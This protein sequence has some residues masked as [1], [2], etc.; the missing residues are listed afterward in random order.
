[1]TRA[2]T[3]PRQARPPATPA[4]A[5][6]APATPH[7]PAGHPD[8]ARRPHGG[9]SPRQQPRPSSPGPHLPAPP[10]L[11]HQLPAPRS[12]HARASTRPGRHQQPG[13]PGRDGG[14]RA[15]TV[16]ARSW[17]PAD[18]DQPAAGDPAGGL[19]IEHHQ[20]GTLVHGTQKN[21]HQ[22]RRVLHNHG[23][24]W[25]GNLNAW[26]LPRPWTFSTRNRRVSSLT[27]DL[28]QAH[29][30]FTMR[31]QPP[32]PAETD[33]SRPSRARRRSLH[34]HTPGASDHFGAVSDYWALTRTP[35]GNNVMSAYPNP[36]PGR[37]R[38]P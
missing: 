21:D 26:Y 31:T 35:A 15:R 23:F 33:D 13:G 14:G 19:V 2:I 22:L 12:Q 11:R 38:S 6:A 3:H 18:Q 29:R 36:E 34:R 5:P 10:S 30:S 4:P 28:R 1:M 20:Q 17:H 25:S 27:A 9:N 32:A 8:Q 7:E 24:R 16:G 37:T